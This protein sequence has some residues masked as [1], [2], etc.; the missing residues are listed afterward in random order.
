MTQTLD[1]VSE[2]PCYSCIIK[3]PKL[4]PLENCQPSQCQ[5]LTDWIMNE[6]QKVQLKQEVVITA[7]KR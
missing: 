1:I 5:A 6:A 2:I 7:R 4:A 3:E